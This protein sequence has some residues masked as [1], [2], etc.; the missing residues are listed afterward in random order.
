[1]FHFSLAANIEYDQRATNVQMQFFVSG[2]LVNPINRQQASSDGLVSGIMR[3]RS[4]FFQS[5]I[6]A[7]LAFSHGHCDGDLLDP[8]LLRSKRVQGRGDHFD[9][10][11]YPT[12]A[13]RRLGDLVRHEASEVLAPPRRIHALGQNR[14]SP[15]PHS[16]Y[17]SIAKAA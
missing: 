12:D 2:R 7:S 6:W 15:R 11:I 3:P 1:M 5:S 14:A 8:P 13:G 10:Q 9:R 4:P 17:M 16:A